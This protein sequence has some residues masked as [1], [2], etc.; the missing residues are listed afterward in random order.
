MTKLPSPLPFLGLLATLTLSA[1]GCARKA[2]PAPVPVQVAVASNFTA[3]MQVLA[4]D[5][6][7][8]TG[9]KA[10]LSFGSTGKFYAQIKAGAP[11][12]LLLAADDKTPAKL[13]D[14]NTAVP[15]SRFT[16]ATG[17]LA[18]WSRTADR[19]TLDALKKG[20]FAHLAL[21]DAKTAPYGAAAEATL[22]HLRLLDALKPKF[23]KGENL[24]QT[25]QFVA[26][27]NAELGF[28][29][30]SQICKDG[31]IT[32]QG[33]VWIVPQEMHPIIRQDAVLLAHGKDNPAAAA[34]LA[35]LK[36]DKARAVIRSYGY[37]LP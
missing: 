35:F 10:Q 6:E 31:V 5:F 17:R 24:A 22:A 15:G 33:S 3:P 32:T 19:A 30:L 20:D 13:E 37:D 27:G 2:P 7:K 4:A 29:A 8:S 14:E 9:H 34:L 23:V 28:V 26:T 25:H 12:D 11:F 21:A 18:L 16:Y 36:T 1:L